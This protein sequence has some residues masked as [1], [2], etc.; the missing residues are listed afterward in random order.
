MIDALDEH[1]RA[2]LHELAVLE[3]AGLGLVGVADEV[4]VHRALGQEGDLLAHREAGAAAPA[5]G[6][7]LELVQDLG[8]RH[9]ERL[10]QG[11]VAA[12]ARVHVESV[13]AGLVDVLEQQQLAHD[14][15]ALGSADFMRSSWRSGSGS[16]PRRTASRT[17]GTSS[18][19]IGPT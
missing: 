10:A 2:L 3:G 17:P 9:R 12:A 13:Q 6:R 16:S 7:H 5:D 1:V 8:G 14:D 11:V 15:A 4:L 18:G 19:R